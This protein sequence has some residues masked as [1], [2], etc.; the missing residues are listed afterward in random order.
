MYSGAPGDILIHPPGC[1]IFHGWTEAGFVNTW[2][3]I[4]G[5]EL[6]GLLERYPLP[7]NTP[8]PMGPENV[9]EQ[10]IKQATEEFA[11]QAVGCEDI[12]QC[13]TTRLVI[14]LYRRYHRMKGA[15]DPL[16]RLREEILRCPERAWNLQEMA[17]QC[18]YSVSH[19]CTLY[20]ERFASS[21]KQDVLAA[22]VELAKKMLCYTDYTAVQIA[23]QCGFA[24]APYFSKCFK[25]GTGLSPQ[26]YR[27]QEKR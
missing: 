11:V 6:C 12:L 9:L 18:G 15:A 24:Y 16:T 27:K 20:K 23:E 25:R 10:Y 26:A 14:D 4:S 1:V 21:P 2:A 19:F 3:Y 22:R 7:L 17:R 8:F 5:E 13:L